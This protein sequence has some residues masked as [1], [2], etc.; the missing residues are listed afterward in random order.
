M[1]TYAVIAAAALLESKSAFVD[2]PL[3]TTIESSLKGLPKKTLL[4]S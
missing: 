4:T 1:S 2:P 3:L